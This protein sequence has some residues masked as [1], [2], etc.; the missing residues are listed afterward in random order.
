M[1]FIIIALLIQIIF[2]IIMDTLYVKFGLFK[3]S[4][5]ADI[6]YWM[7]LMLITIPLY[8]KGYLMIYQKKWLAVMLSMISFL[9]YGVVAIIVMLIF[10][11][12]VLNAPL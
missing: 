4:K 12:E 6:I 8:F 2:G 9:V 7:M 11:T 10:H 5:Y 1:Q 3:F